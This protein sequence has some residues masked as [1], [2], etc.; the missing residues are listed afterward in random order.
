MGRALLGHYQGNPV[1]KEVSRRGAIGKKRTDRQII[2]LV[3]VSDISYFFCSGEGKEE[4][5][6]PGGSGGQ[7]FI[8]NPRREGLPGRGRGGVRVFAG[9][10]ECG[11]EGLIFLFFGAKI[12]TK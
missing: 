6:S 3:D 8:E 12:P 7:F 4:S 9:N 2:I 5:E 1:S 11:G 10:G